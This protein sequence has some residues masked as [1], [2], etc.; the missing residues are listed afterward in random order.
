M[1]SM[2][3]QH[4]ASIYDPLPAGPYIRVLILEP[5]RSRQPIRCRL[6]TVNL[7]ED[8]DFEAISYVWGRGIKR[9]KIICNDQRVKIT[10]NLLQALIALRS[11]SRSRT[12]WADSISIN[13][14]DNEEK[15]HQVALMGPI[16]NRARRVLIHL[17]GDDRGH[18]NMAASFVSEKCA[19]IRHLVQT[20]RAGRPVEETSILPY[21]SAEEKHLLMNDARL[22]ALKYLLDHMWFQRGWVIQEAVLAQ[23]AVIVWGSCGTISFTSLMICQS[24][25]FRN[26]R[27][28][29]STRYLLEPA[30]LSDLYRYRF[31]EEAQAIGYA[32]LETQPSLLRILDLA[33]R[34]KLQNPRDRVFAFLYLDGADDQAT[35][36]T[37]RLTSQSNRLAVQPNYIKSVAEVYTDFVRH[38]V[39][40]GDLRWLHYVQ[41]TQESLMQPSFASW[42]PRWDVREQCSLVNKPSQQQSLQ[43]GR[44]ISANRDQE[45]ARLEGANLIVQGVVFDRVRA[46]CSSTRLHS[47]TLTEVASL[48]R[49]VKSQNLGSAYPPEYRGLALLYTL[50]QAY[51]QG[52]WSQW[53]GERD[54]FW[55]F[56]RAAEEGSD[57]VGLELRIPR[58]QQC[59]S[60]AS[61]GRKV[62]FT[63]R[64]YFALAPQITEKNDMCCII[65]GC[66]FPFILRQRAEVTRDPSHEKKQQ[67][68]M[69]GDAWVAGKQAVSHPKGDMFMSRFG[70]KHSKEWVDWE[71]EE[72]DIYLV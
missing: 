37:D 43:S 66:C 46:C 12:V 64:G 26:F 2:R 50:T 67:Y 58:V 17:A 30:V 53:L 20:L 49:M 52:S 21:P 39:A 69:I 71:L 60:V 25:L 48:W 35:M 51:F 72:G 45:M 22:K 13:Q 34:A 29:Y 11:P 36:A 19:M 63:D 15:G 10:A 61:I 55:Q 7:E 56:L 4:S 38:C 47:T 24:W 42:V 6:S 54:L 70:G 28:L 65:F 44:H 23:D 18:A 31:R 1:E 33:R 5:G 40:S 68:H 32:R 8:P 16:Y 9:K 14:K 62:V 3:Q 59:I 27:E 41:H 57:T